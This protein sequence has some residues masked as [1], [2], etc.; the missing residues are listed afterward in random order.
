MGLSEKLLP[1]E[2]L[3][4]SE[5]SSGK[6]SGFALGFAFGKSLGFRLSLGQSFSRQPLWLFNSLSHFTKL[7][8][9]LMAESGPVLPG[10]A[11]TQGKVYHYILEFI[12]IYFKLGFFSLINAL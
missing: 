7:C 11:E 1:R 9:D 5:F 4:A 3:N 12:D 6:L 10:T 8:S 2:S